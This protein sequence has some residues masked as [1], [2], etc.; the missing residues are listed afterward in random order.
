MKTTIIWLILLKL[1]LMLII[2][3][4]G[5]LKNKLEDLSLIEINNKLKK[6]IICEGLNFDISAIKRYNYIDWVQFE[7]SSIDK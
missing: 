6:R 7:Y 4:T 3:K 2:K 5:E 1:M